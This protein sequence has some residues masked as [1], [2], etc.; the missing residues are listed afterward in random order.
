MGYRFTIFINGPVV[1]ERL[2]ILPT[3]EVI[4]RPSQKLNYV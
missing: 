3:P 2:S 4:A 1:P